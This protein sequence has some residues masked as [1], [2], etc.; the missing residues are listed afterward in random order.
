MLTRLELQNFKSFAQADIPLERL[1]VFVGPNSSGKTS[2]LDAIALLMAIPGFETVLRPPSSEPFKVE[3]IYKRGAS[4]KLIMRLHANN[5]MLEK[6]V[7]HDGIT[8]KTSEKSESFINGVWQK[9]ESV[10]NLV[11]MVPIASL[12]L[13][14]E[15]LAAPSSSE[16]PK[17]IL[18]RDGR[19]LA[20]V[21]VNVALNQPEA[22]SVIQEALTAVIPQVKQVRFE[23]AQ[24]KEWQQ[25]SLPMEALEQIS[26]DSHQ[27]HLSKLVLQCYLM[28]L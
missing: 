17:P 22:W 15:A 14:N 18:F 26:D 16:G 7:E 25:A 23:R 12:R 1:T 24:V 27:N 28:R 19:G 10:N 4:T 20:S 11:N 2:V 5:I 6:T 9:T 21:L 3:D 13:D 8:F